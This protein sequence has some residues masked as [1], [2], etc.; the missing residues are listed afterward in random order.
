MTLGMGGEEKKTTGIYTLPERS[1]GLNFGAGTLYG[2]LN[3]IL[4][5]TSPLSAGGGERGG[6]KLLPNFQKGG[7]GRTLV[8]RG[9]FVKKRGVTFLRG[10]GG[11]GGGGAIFT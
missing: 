5:C 3:H 7:V 8:F 11:W 10:R 9:G 1:N 4:L 2:L 6:L